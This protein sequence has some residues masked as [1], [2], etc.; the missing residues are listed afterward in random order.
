MVCIV[1]SILL[2]LLCICYNPPKRAHKQVYSS[3]S[4]SYGLQFVSKPVWAIW[5]AHY[6]PND[7]LR[8]ELRK[9]ILKEKMSYVEIVATTWLTKL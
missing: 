3:D 8:T 2:P 1:G 4:R 5:L 7:V 9:L 6:Q